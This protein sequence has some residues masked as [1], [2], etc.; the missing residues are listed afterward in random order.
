MIFHN[1]S[2]PLIRNIR[3]KDAKY[4]QIYCVKLMKVMILLINDGFGMA[5]RMILYV[6]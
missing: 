1:C 2:Y 6:S 5:N 3:F 4:H